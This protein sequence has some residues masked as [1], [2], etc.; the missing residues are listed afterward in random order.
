MDERWF[1]SITLPITA[2]QFEE[3]PRNPTYQYEYFDHR[4]WLTPRPKMYHAMLD[5]QSSAI[6]QE[7]SP[8]AHFDVRPLADHDWPALLAPFA[9]AFRQVAPLSALKPEEMQAA[10]RD[11]LNATRSGREGPLIS[12][13]CFVATEGASSG[14]KSSNVVGAIL[15]TLLPNIDLTK[16]TSFRWP[17][18]PPHDAIERKLGLPHLTWIFVNPCE[19]SQGIGS[20]LLKAAVQ[21]L[22]TIGY[23]RL[24]STFLLGNESSTLWHW[25]NGFQLLKYPGSSRKASPSESNA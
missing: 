22:I 1:K 8:G 10:A 5:L 14:K 11:C 25:R 19:T 16:F 20:A 17:E 3:L 6:S 23:P 9:E 15:T 18:T 13:A 4:A 2:E 7:V 24:A 12:S 21:G